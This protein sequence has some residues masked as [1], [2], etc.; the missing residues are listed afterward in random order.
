LEVIAL[1]SKASLDATNALFVIF[2][3]ALF[4]TGLHELALLVTA[5]RIAMRG[6]QK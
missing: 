4:A 1:S 3:L 6:M 5:G 2:V